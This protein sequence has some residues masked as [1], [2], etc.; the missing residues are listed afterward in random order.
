MVISP[1]LGGMIDIIGKRG[2]LAL[3]TAVL[4]IPV[5]GLLAFSD[6]Y[7]LVATVWL[8]LTYSFAAASMWPSIPLVVTQATVGTAMGLTTS[9]QMIGIGISNLVVGQILGSDKAG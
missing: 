9:I 2:Y 6:V 8:G 7:P 5:F 3:L 1:F 4:T